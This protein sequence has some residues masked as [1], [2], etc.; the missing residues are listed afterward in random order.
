MEIHVIIQ[1]VSIIN[2]AVISYDGICF[3]S[4]GRLDLD[5]LILRVCFLFSLRHSGQ[6]STIE[7]RLLIRKSN[8]INTT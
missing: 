4:S 5:V 3:A 8:K 7:T 2:A 6:D 1:I